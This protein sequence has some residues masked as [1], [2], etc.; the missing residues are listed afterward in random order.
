MNFSELV[1]KRRSYRKL[2]PITISPEIIKELLEIIEFAPS[3]DNKQPWRFIFVY[4]EANLEELYGVFHKKNNWIKNASLLIAVFSNRDFACNIDE[5]DYYLFD[6]GIAVSYLML[7][8][9]EM[10]L[11][12]HPTSYYDEKK[13]KQILNLSDEMV[14]ITI[15]AVGKHSDTSE[16][17]LSPDQENAELERPKRFSLQYLSYLNKYAE[18]Y[19]KDKKRIEKFFE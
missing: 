16:V 7:R 19:E 5:R 18:E 14:L 2:K 12:A 13:A 10:G 8:A 11:V 1:K 9:T 4:D 17:V 3:C 6:S 15:L